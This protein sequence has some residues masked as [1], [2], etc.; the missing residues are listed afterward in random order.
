MKAEPAACP[1]KMLCPRGGH[2]KTARA[3]PRGKQPAAGGGAGPGSGVTDVALQGHR[4]PPSRPL[5]KALRSGISFLLLCALPRYLHSG[6][7][8]SAT[9][10]LQTLPSRWSHCLQ[11]TPLP[12]LLAG[13]QAA[14]GKMPEDELRVPHPHRACFSA[15]C[16]RPL[17]CSGPNLVLRLLMPSCRPLRCRQRQA[18]RA[19]RPSVSPV[20]LLLPLRPVWEGA[21]D[22]L[23]PT[24]TPV[25]GNS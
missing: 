19:L 22:R 8:L 25:S 23:F 15:W 3:K 11:P 7:S 17:R 4:C 20:C 2:H 1:S 21:L 14:Q 5:Q 12:G 13:S 24:E 10:L 9:G 6:S 16:H 18:P